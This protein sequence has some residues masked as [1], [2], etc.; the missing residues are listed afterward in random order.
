M[1]YEKSLDDSYIQEMY[2]NIMEVKRIDSINRNGSLIV[3]VDNCMHKFN[4]ENY[5]NYNKNEEIKV[6]TDGDYF[7][8]SKT[9]V[10]MHNTDTKYFYVILIS[11]FVCI[12]IWIIYI[13]II[14]N[15][16]FSI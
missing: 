6:Y 1:N 11:S 10:V 2:G 5:S 7:S 15:D 14:T 9:N 8:L 16:K 13:N 12:V 3:N 4:I